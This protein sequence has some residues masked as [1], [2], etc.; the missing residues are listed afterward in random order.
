MISL[1]SLELT[2]EENIFILLENLDELV[3]LKKNTR[4]MYSCQYDIGIRFNLTNLS[5]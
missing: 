4:S 3:A 2:V 1:L 5:R